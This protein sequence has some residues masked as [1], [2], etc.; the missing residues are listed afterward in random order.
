Y[1]HASSPQTL[2]DIPRVQDISSGKQYAQSATNSDANKIADLT[3][4]ADAL[5]ARLHDLQ[6]TRDD[7]QQLVDTMQR[8]KAALEAEN[9]RQKKLLDTAG[10]I[11]V[12]GDSVLTGEQ[13]AA[14]FKARG[15]HYQ[16]SGDTTIAQLADLFVEEGKAE[17]VRGDIAFAQSILETG[18][19]G[20]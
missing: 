12:M 4:S 5:D 14:W 13:I 2:L 6:K 1:T 3:R 8:A 19:F 11:T 15:A 17:H 7:Q 10:T 9:N 20:H 16:L 18:S